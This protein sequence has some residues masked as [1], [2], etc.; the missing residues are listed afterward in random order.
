MKIFVALAVL[1]SFGNS[2]F[3]AEC[4]SKALGLVKL[5][6]N[7]EL[8][9]YA[10]AKA[11]SNCA[12]CDGAVSSIAEARIEAKAL[13]ANDTDVKKNDGQLGGIV[14]HAICFSEDAVFVTE[15]YTEANKN[16]ALRIKNEILQSIE[17]T[18]SGL[19]PNQGGN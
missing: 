6:V 3:A 4:P 14:D 1:A 17:T 10:T 15:L 12:S 13:L 2:S 11:K 8:N 16:K 18:K 19:F 5:R 7:G 9:V